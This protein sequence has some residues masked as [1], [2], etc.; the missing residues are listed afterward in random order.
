MLKINRKVEYALMVL[1]FML[2]K[3]KGELTSTREICQNFHTPFDTTAKVMQTMN[4]KKILSSMQGVK[5]GY[6]LTCNLNKINYIEFVNIIEGKK[7]SLGCDSKGT[8][9]L[10]ETCN[11]K[12]PITHLNNKLVNYLSTITVEELLHY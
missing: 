2:K 8:C 6:F 11:I 3:N 4:N 10:Q 7:I 9:H 5:G 12:T 1:K